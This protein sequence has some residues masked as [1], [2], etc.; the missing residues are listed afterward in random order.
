[1]EIKTCYMCNAISTSR[2]L[3]PPKFIY[4]ESKDVDGN[5]YRID[6]I[7]VFSLLFAHGKKRTYFAL[8][9]GLFCY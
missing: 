5:N 6:L 9:L 3:V 8:L 7:T 4:P 2:V 1:M